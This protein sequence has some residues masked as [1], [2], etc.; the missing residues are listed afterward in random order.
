MFSWKKE[1]T[2]RI[3]IDRLMLAIQSQRHPFDTYSVKAI[4][5]KK[6]R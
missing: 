1:D 5:L 2:K 6:P 4:H 3:V